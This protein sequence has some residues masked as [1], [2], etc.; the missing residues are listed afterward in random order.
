MKTSHI[1]TS[2]YDHSYQAFCS[3]YY[4]FVTLFLI[5]F[6]ISSFNVVNAQIANISASSSAAIIDQDTIDYKY[7]QIINSCNFA[8]GGTGCVSVRSGPGVNFKKVNRLRNGIVLKI[9]EVN[10]IGKESW[11]KISFKDE[12]VNYP[13]RANTDWYV[14]ARY[15]MPLKEAQAESYN[16][17]KVYDEN[18]RIEIDLSE[19]TLYAYEKNKLF[20]KTKISTGLKDSPTL[21]GEYYI[22]YK[23][24]SR[25]MQGPDKKAS[26]TPK[27]VTPLTKDYYD[28]PGVP[29]TMY[30]AED[31]SAIHGAYW[32]NNFGRHHSHGCVNLNIK[33]SEK[34]YMWASAGTNVIVRN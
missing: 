11:Y 7:V 1:L 12:K 2:S 20:M 13:E 23:T 17:N 15:A 22:H 4:R 3:F 25:Y 10:V 34:L 5:S 6:F 31:G 16:P 33:D 14:N 24:P 9:S 18:R 8:F 28:L 19:Q 26:T 21:P 29:W 30:F 27:V 32:H